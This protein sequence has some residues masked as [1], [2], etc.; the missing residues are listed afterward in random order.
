MAFRSDFDLT[1]QDR[2][3]LGNRRGIA[4]KDF[5]DKLAEKVLRQRRRSRL[6]R[7][8]RSDPRAATVT[9]RQ[10]GLRLLG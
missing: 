8:V 7:I 6:E 2:P 4:R 5:V 10:S 1:S 9:S 3:T